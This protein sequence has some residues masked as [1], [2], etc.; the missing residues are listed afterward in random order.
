MTLYLFEYLR[1]KRR[2]VGVNTSDLTLLLE[3]SVDFCS[4]KS[5]NNSKSSHQSISNKKHSAQLNIRFFFT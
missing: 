2:G 5:Q 1:V 3:K 4:F